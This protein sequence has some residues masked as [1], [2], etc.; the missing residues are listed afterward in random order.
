MAHQ[1]SIKVHFCL[2]NS[3]TIPIICIDISKLSIAVSCLVKL[4]LS[5][6]TLLSLKSCFNKNV[7]LKKKSNISR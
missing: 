5:G 6:G 3:V 4:T 2:A 7:I 1:F